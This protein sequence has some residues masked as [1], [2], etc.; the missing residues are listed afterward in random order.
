MLSMYVG[1]VADT[2]DNYNGGRLKAIISIDKGQRMEDI[3]YAFPLIPKMVQ[4]RPKIGEAVVVFVANDKEPSSQRW[5]MGPIISQPD[6]MQRDL[7]SSFSATRLLENGG[8]APSK[9]ISL[10]PE[11]EG[12]MPKDEDIALLG[13]KNTDVILTE[14]DVRIRA[15]ARLTKPETGKV[16]FNTGAPAYIKLKYHEK[17]LVTASLP[18]ETV[19]HTKT[20]STATIVADKINL[21]SPNGDEGFSIADKEEGIN[22]EKMKQII[23]KA[24]KLPYGDLLCDFFS[25]F[26]DMFRNHVHEYHGMPP[27]LTEPAAAAFMAKYPTKESMEDQLLSKD[28]KIN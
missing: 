18:G 19:P 8:S 27:V 4:V 26:L 15:G 13:R 11:N 16:E 1:Y 2:K 10:F 9:S 21:I 17:P 6:K 23:E 7:F 5:Y 14:N 12:A 25:A 28:V 20:R 3:P 24:H 22:D